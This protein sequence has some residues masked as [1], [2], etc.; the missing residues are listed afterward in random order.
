MQSVWSL[1]RQT[2][3]NWKNIFNVELPYKIP[4]YPIQQTRHCKINQKSILQ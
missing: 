2:T 1:S 4:I 3:E